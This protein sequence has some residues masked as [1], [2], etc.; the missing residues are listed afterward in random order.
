MGHVFDRHAIVFLTWALDG[1]KWSLYPGRHWILGWTGPKAS[2]DDL[3][4]TEILYPHH[5]SSIIQPIAQSLYWVHCNGTVLVLGYDERCSNLQ[6]IHTRR[7]WMKVHFSRL[8]SL[9][10]LVCLC[11]TAVIILQQ[12][13]SVMAG[14]FAR[15]AHDLYVKWQH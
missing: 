12:Y 3:E 8:T 11:K 9:D 14:F 13:L 4:K 2:L 10:I 15:C 5:D 1:D 6:T 7:E